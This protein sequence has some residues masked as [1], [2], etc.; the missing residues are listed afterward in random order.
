M[1]TPT[2]AHEKPWMTVWLGVQLPPGLPI[3]SCSYSTH[4]SATSAAL[5]PFGTFDVLHCRLLSDMQL[6]K[7]RET[8]CAKHAFCALRLKTITGGGEDAV[9]LMPKLRA[10]LFIV[11]A[12][13]ARPG[14]SRHRYRACGHTERHSCD[15][16]RQ[17]E[18]SIL[19][20]GSDVSF[21]VW[22][23]PWFHVPL[24]V[25][26]SPVPRLHPAPSMAVETCAS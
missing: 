13:V 18:H 23:S 4:I 5:C 9:A 6:A 19:P 3:A 14:C 24:C 16:Y 15:A 25:T 8:T 1:R 17:R 7:R 11:I 20:F 21:I 26:A 2:N 12:V 22:I 10:A